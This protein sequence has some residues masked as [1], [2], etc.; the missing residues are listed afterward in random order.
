[1][2]LETFHQR[3]APQLEEA[4]LA[5]LA[6]QEGR[7]AA[8]MRY[9][10]ASGGKR[11]RPL[12]VLAFNHALGGDVAAGLPAACAVEYV[13]TYS[14]I[15]DD[16]P[17]MDDDDYRRG[18]P[19]VH[20]AYDEATAIL[21]G[22]AL[23]T[24][25]FMWLA[26]G[27]QAADQRLA[28]VELL[29]TA[30]GESGMVL[31]QMDDIQAEHQTLTLAELKQLH[32]RKTGQLIRFSILAGAISANVSAEGR[33]ACE[34]FARHYGLA[35]QIQNDLQEVLWDDEHR[36]KKQV[37]DQAL[38]KNTYPSLLGVSGALDALKAERAQCQTALSALRASVATLDEELLQGFL[39]YLEM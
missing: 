24:H 32:S 4:L 35:Y 17:A 27:Q 13:H 8:S 5:P 23:L 30:A 29:A 25:A 2:K 39:A 28:L 14:L 9:A 16:L 33:M 11:I 31:G 22:D 18:K 19:S 26:G 1:M 15:H 34:Q 37:S 10:L 21:A 3:L 7:L 38:E 36:G 6:E 12:F 20:K